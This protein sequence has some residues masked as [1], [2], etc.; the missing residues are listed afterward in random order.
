MLRKTHN[1]INFWNWKTGMDYPVQTPFYCKENLF[2][3]IGQLFSVT[4]VTSSRVRT[5]THLFSSQSDVHSKLCGWILGLFLERDYVSEEHLTL[6][7][8]IMCDKEVK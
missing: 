7:T 2:Q 3:K 5:K 4:K 1:K 6:K 8:R